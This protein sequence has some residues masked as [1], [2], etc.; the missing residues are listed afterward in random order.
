MSYPWPL[1]SKYN[2]ENTYNDI[3]YDMTAP[4]SADGSNFP[5][6]GYQNGRPTAPVATYMTG[7]TY[8][9]VRVNLSCGS[10]CGVLVLDCVPTPATIACASLSSHFDRFEEILLT[11]TSGIDSPLLAV[12]R[13]AVDHVSYRCPTT[14]AQ[15]FK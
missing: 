6:K 4:L 15:H 10:L 5:C 3:D 9:M 12:Q 7:S 13:M 2:P 11:M 14:T 1:R 8:N